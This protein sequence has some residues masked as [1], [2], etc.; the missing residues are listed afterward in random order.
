MR[1]TN[2]RRRALSLAAAAAVMAPAA[3]GLITP[4]AN[5]TSVKPDLESG[6]PNCMDL[7]YDYGF[8]PGKM[9]NGKRVENAPGEYTDPTTGIEITFSGGTPYVA[10]TSTVGPEAVIVKG[11][12]CGQRVQVRRNGA[13]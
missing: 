4:S 11:G 10:W 3:I 1:T 7:G 13:E 2:L 8:K 6:N 9:V 12:P 5:A